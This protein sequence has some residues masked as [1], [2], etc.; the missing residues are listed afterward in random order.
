M[1][2]VASL[3]SQTTTI[4]VSLVIRSG[5]GAV[6][7]TDG[8]GSVDVEA[9]RPGDG[10][11]DVVVARTLTVCEPSASPANS[12][13]GIIEVPDQPSVSIL[14]WKPDSPEVGSLPVQTTVTEED[15]E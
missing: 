4:A 14:Y 3:P 9:D 2:P 10:V 11:A 8:T 15:G 7:C 5:A 12:W 6:I 13:L 1:P